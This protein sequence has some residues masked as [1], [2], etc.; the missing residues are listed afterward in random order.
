MAD[1]IKS[2]PLSITVDDGYQRIP[3]NNKYGDEIGVFYF[4]PTD[5]GIVERYNTLAEKF[6]AI[7]E[8]L[9]AVDGDEELQDEEREIKYLE[10]L[11]EAKKR[12]YEAVDELFGGNAA[13]AFFGKVHP[14]SPV[15]G[16]FY[17]ETV[18]KTVGE[19]IGAQF[20][21][22]TKKMSARVEKYTNRAQ[23]RAQKK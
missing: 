16:N 5:I 4:N 2:M 11:N 14:F 12:L 15:D 17:C 22:E 9:Q 19:F 1:E 6:D 7:T 20:D 13:E 21:V 23:R 18:L 10:M 3:I 8:P